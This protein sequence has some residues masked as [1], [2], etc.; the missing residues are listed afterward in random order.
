MKRIERKLSEV[1]HEIWDADQ[2]LYRNKG[3]PSDGP[4]SAMV[5]IAGRS[6]YSH[7]AK[8]IR[9]VNKKDSTL[10]VVE[11]REW[12]GAGIAALATQVEK[13][14]GQ[15]DVF[16]TNPHNFTEYSRTAAADFIR[17][18]EGAR[19]GYGAV[20]RA[21]LDFLPVVRWLGKHEYNLDNGNKKEKWPFCSQ[22]CT[23]ADDL[24]G[25]FDPVPNLANWIT[26]PGD[27]ARSL[28]YRYMF[29]LVPEE[30]KA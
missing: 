9:L 2:L 17:R 20:L 10:F 21:S 13:Y 6:D 1:A 27:Q 24:G 11:T 4:L 19:Y 18:Y 3:F 15:I 30:V 23:M 12:E 16:R 22:L 25:G 26:L 28:F 8:A 7:S 5:R 14:P 29:T